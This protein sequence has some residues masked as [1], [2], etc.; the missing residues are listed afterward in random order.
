MLTYSSSHGQMSLILEDD[1]SRCGGGAVCSVDDSGGCC[2]T[3]KPEADDFRRWPLPL[4][5]LLVLP[6]AGLMTGDACFDGF[7]MMFTV[8]SLDEDVLTTTGD[9][10]WVSGWRAAVPVWGSVGCV[11]WAVGSCDSHGQTTSSFATTSVELF[12]R[13]TGVLVRVP[14]PP[15]EDAGSTAP[16]ESHGQTSKSV[17]GCLSTALDDELLAADGPSWWSTDG[18]G[19]NRTALLLIRL[20]LLLLPA[21]GGLIDSHGQTSSAGRLVLLVDDK[22]GGDSLLLPPDLQQNKTQKPERGMSMIC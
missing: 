6:P 2:C 22:T 17:D 9:V 15:P 3:V 11:V 5:A 1:L 7:N 4:L 16:A 14:P 8:T 12:C 19:V 20:L 10:F 18:P 13:G 21:L